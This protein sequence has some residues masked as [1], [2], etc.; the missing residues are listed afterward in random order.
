M[1]PECQTLLEYLGPIDDRLGRYEWE[2]ARIRS[3]QTI[4][5]P[6]NWKVAIEAFVEPYHV[7][8]T[9][10]QLLRWGHGKATPTEVMNTALNQTL[11]R[12]LMTSFSVLFVVVSLY[13]FGGEALK[14]FSIAIIVGVFVG[15]YSSIFVAGALAHDMKL[16]AQDLMTIK[17]DDPELDA[18][19]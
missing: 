2:H 19:P 14:G 9:H 1:D 13:L 15:T 7:V 17:K 8:A 18:L 12:T 16:K 6:V 5:F 11:S 4:I 10:P 3:H